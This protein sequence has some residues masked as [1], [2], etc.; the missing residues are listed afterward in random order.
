MRICILG[1]TGLV[2]RETIDLAARA[3]P[4]AELDLYA[5]R[6]QQLSH[7][8]ILPAQDTR[9]G[10]ED[11]RRQRGPLQANLRCLNFT[12]FRVHI[13]SPVRAPQ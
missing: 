4:G 12:R 10:T 8:K 9:G 1:A 2:G 3:W 11:D 7:C 6:D 5:S 13:G